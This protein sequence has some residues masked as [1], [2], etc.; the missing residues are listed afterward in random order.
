LLWH[1][2]DDSFSPV[3]HT[4]WLASRIANA[5]VQVQADTAHFGAVEILPQAL[6]WVTGP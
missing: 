3:G 6:A 1:G 2:A 5:R 4:E